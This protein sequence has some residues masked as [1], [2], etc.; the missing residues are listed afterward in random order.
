V[1]ARLIL[2]VIAAVLGVM[3]W[4]APV[5]AGGSNSIVVVAVVNG[6]P[7]GPLELTRTCPDGA[8]G[9]ATSAPFTTSVNPAIAQ[10]AFGGA[11]PSTTCTVTVTQ[12]DG[13]T[14]SFACVVT[15]PAD[16]VGMSCGAGND[17]VTNVTSRSA[18]AT[19]TVTFDPAPPQAPAAVVAAPRTTG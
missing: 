10:A 9:N 19:I 5:S 11:P 4:A 17:S 1:R 16:A 2:V 13:M 3:A 15:P 18:T 7:T 6:T 14:A 8:P 12:A